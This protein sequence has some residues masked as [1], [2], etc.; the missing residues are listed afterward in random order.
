MNKFNIEETKVGWF[1]EKISKKGKQYFIG[2]VLIGGKS[3][4]M[5]L[6]ESGQK[7]NRKIFAMFSSKKSNFV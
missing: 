5:L 1:D 3:Y 2:N 4:E 6:F 7:G